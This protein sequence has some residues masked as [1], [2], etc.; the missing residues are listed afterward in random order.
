MSIKATTALAALGLLFGANAAL[1]ENPTATSATTATTSATATFAA[2]GNVAI[3]D[4]PKSGP[5]TLTGTIKDVEDNS[6]F[7]LQD[8]NG[9]TIDVETNNELALQTGD[10]V[11]V[12]GTLD[13]EAMG[14]G[15]EINSA[16]V[17]KL[18]KH[19]MGHAKAGDNPRAAATTAQFNSKISELPDE[20]AITIAGTVKST[21]GNNFTLADA[22]GDTIEVET[23]AELSLNAGDYVEVEGMLETEGSTQQI[24]AASVNQIDATNP[25]KSAFNT[26]KNATTNAV[27]S[28]GNAISSAATATGNAVTGAVNTLTGAADET[29]DATDAM[30]SEKSLISELPR[31][32]AIALSGTVDSVDSDE[33]SFILRDQAGKTID[34]HSPDQLAVTKGDYVLVQGKLTS[35]F[36]GMG[37][38]IQASSVKVSVR[39]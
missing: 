18:G 39:R 35:E 36:A 6:N 26:A 5:I 29:A 1:A 2:E 27:D 12:Q 30:I 11:K 22:H 24:S 33:R 13:S 25:A 14:M 37:K 16:S 31:K 28:A 17:T 21:N 9:D 8:A 4:L 15:R 3:K 34:V 38:E 20:G 23:P 7:I 19:S 32:G 10:F